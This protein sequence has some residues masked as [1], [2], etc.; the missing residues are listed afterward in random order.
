MLP[1]EVFNHPIMKQPKKRIA[2][3]DDCQ[4]MIDGLMSLL[5][6]HKSLDV[7]ITSTSPNELLSKMVVRPVDILLIDI[8]MP[9][10]RSEYVVKEV[11]ERFPDV[12]VLAMSAECQTTTVSKMVELAHISGS[13]L[14]SSCK[15]ELIPAL[16]KL[17]AGSLW[18]SESI[19]QEMSQIINRK[20]ESDTF[21]LT[22]REL[23]VV[24]LIEQEYSNKEI[25]ETLFISERTVETHRKNIFRKTNTNSIIGL[26]KYVYQHNLV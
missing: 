14:K 10:M 18:F 22:T 8:V 19:I 4:I 12:K 6:G 16:E 20:R 5:Q 24:K 11:K 17:S 1:L 9:A 3:A 21:H 13:I 26:I 25:A 7:V 2:I 15:T 23:E